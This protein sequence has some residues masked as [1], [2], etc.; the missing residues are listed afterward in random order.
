MTRDSQE[1]IER[2]EKEAERYR[3]DDEK[4]RQK[5]DAKN[6]LENYSYRLK[7]IFAGLQKDINDTIHWLERNQTANKEEF[8][9]KQKELEQVTATKLSQLW[10][11]NPSTNF[12]L[13]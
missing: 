6:G 10:V 3:I 12:E 7:N 11:R 9:A 2:M 5:I 4:Q 1:E 8:E 13:C